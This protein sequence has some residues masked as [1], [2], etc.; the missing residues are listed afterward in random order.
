MANKSKDVQNRELKAKLKQAGKRVEYEA[1][2]AHAFDNAPFINS[3]P[4][5]SEQK[6]EEEKSYLHLMLYLH[7]RLPTT[8]SLDVA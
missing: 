7:L 3:S 2:R 4:E 8:I 5:D 6:L 1:L